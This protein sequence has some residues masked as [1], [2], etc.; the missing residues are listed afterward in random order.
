LSYYCEEQ[1]LYCDKTNSK[2]TTLSWCNQLVTDLLEVQD[3]LL[4][5]IS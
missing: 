2:L 3:G 4:G 5:W 1:T